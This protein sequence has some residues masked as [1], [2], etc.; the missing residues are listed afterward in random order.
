ML[1]VLRIDA[2]LGKCS[3]CAVMV[4]V[5]MIKRV[6]SNTQSRPFTWSC[7]L[8]EVTEHSLE[9]LGSTKKRASSVGR[10]VLSAEG[11]QMVLVV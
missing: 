10:K 1:I 3:L 8:V 9:Q 6:L 4:N 11:D 7:M 5:W 2:N